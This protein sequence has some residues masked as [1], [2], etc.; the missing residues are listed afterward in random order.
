[1]LPARS[2][3]SLSSS[4][5]QFPVLVFRL[6]EAPE[7]HL[8]SLLPLEVRLVRVPLWLLSVL[9]QSVNVRPHPCLPTEA[10]LRAVRRILPSQQRA[11][12]LGA[13]L[14]GPVRFGE[15]TT[16]AW[17]PASPAYG[18]RVGSSMTPLLSRTFVMKNLEKSHVE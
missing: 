6:L 10:T 16:P 3:T 17:E 7:V 12:F 8:R 15:A 4:S 18:P 1:M 5:S 2:R 11:T 13:G 9:D 14:D